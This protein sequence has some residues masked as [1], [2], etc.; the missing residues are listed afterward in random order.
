MKAIDDRALPRLACR[1]ARCTS[2]PSSWATSTPTSRCSASRSP[3]RPTSSS[4]CSSWPA[5]APT[6]C[7]RSRSTD[8]AFVPALHSVGA[9][10]AEGQA[11]VA[12]RAPTPSTSSTSPRSATIW[13]YGSGYG[14]NALLGKKCYAL[15]IAS[16]IA[17]D[18]GWMAEHMLILKLT[19][20]E[21][22]VHYIAAAFPIGLRQDQP[23][24]DRRRPSP[25]GRPRWSATTSPGCASARTAASTPSTPSSASSASRPAPASTT[26]P[27]AMRDHREGQLGLHQRRPDRRRRRVVGGHDRRAAGAPDRLARQRLD[28]RGRRGRHQG[29]PPEQP[30]LHARPSSAR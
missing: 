6:C 17:R 11:D 26:N 7:A 13:S 29:G 18:E 23:R 9:P 16:A 3:T 30:L 4:R 14:G 27:N 5:A 15:R 20:P 19:S 1:A 8:A 21:G 2:S 12:G 10:L 25:A 22:S 28:A 24:D